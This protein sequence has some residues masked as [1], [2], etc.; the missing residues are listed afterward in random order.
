MTLVIPRHFA[1]RAALV[2]TSEANVDINTAINPMNIGNDR[3]VDLRI[4]TPKIL[5]ETIEK[6]KNQRRR[7]Y[8]FDN[9]DESY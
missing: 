7:R 6:F 8:H 4:F 3:I 5:K 9:E 1:Q 2:T